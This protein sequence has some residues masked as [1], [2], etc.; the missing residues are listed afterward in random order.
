LTNFQTFSLSESGEKLL[1]YHQFRSRHTS[2]MSV[3][4]LVKCQCIKKQQLKTTAHP[5]SASCCCKTDT[6]NI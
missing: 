1:Y 3:H 2:D 5:K 4:Y 6:L